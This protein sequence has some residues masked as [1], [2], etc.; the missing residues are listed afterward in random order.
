MKKWTAPAA[1]RSPEEAAGTALADELKAYET[2][3]VEVEGQ[4]A[5]GENTTSAVEEDWF[6]E[7]ATFGVEEE[8]HGH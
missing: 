6:D 4:A 8:A 5:V 1:P 2:Q 7:E 3:E